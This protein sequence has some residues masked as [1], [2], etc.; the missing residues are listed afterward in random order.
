MVHFRGK[1]TTI[2][3]QYISLS[4]V[5]VGFTGVIFAAV[6]HSEEKAP[7]FEGKRVDWILL[8]NGRFCRCFLGGETSNI[9]YFYHE[10]WGIDPIYDKHIFQMG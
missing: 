6:K 2:T 4:E 9:F 3:I 7:F 5:F 10:N 1:P 8:Q